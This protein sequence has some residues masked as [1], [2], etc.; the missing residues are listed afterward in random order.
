MIRG[1]TLIELLLVITILSV[2]TSLAIMT[3][4]NKTEEYRIDQAALEIQ[5]V[6]EASLAYNV[7]QGS[8]PNANKINSCTPSN[9]SDKFIT[10]YLPNGNYRSNYGDNY[11]WS[12]KNEGNAGPLFWAALKIPF[13][14]TARNYQIAT[15]LAARLP[16]AIAVEDFTSSTPCM[17]TSASCYVRA[18]VAIP[19]VSGGGKNNTQMAGFG[20]CDPTVSGAQFGSSQEITCTQQSPADHYLIQFS[21]PTDYAGQIYLSPNFYKAAAL[22][23][24][25]PPTILTVLNTKTTSTSC[26]EISAGSSHYAC[27]II[28]T[29]L[30]DSG[31]HPVVSPPKGTPGTIG[32]SYIAYCIK[33][34]KSILATRW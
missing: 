10:D 6:L 1:Y 20:Y 34:N 4:R 22:P 2:V 26:Q 18:E 12:S 24:A 11:C 14:D 16:N 31:T 19:A 7:D 17:Q 30:Y 21:C 25:N 32:A 23:E 29:G 3:Y 27:P 9:P 13:A 28:V 8:W 33:P 5:H 15:R